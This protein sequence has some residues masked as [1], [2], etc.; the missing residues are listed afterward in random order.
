MQKEAK[1]ETL[2]QV[3]AQLAEPRCLEFWVIRNKTKKNLANAPTRRELG[4]FAYSKNE[5]F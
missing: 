2:C 3:Y 4:A 5:V 1:R